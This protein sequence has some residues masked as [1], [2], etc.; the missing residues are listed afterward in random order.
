MWIR[1]YIY[2]VLI[3]PFHLLL[4]TVLVGSAMDLVMSNMIYGVVA[5]GFLIP[6]ERLL[7]KFFGFDN[8]GTLSAAGSFAG[9]ALFS[10][11]I[12]KINKSKSGGR[13]GSGGDDGGQDRT[14]TIRKG[15]V[16]GTNGMIDP[17]AVIAGTDGTGTSG[18]GTSG[19][20]TAKEESQVKDDSAEEEHEKKEIEK[21]R[22]AFREHAEKALTNEEIAKKQQK[23]L[24]EDTE[25]DEKESNSPKINT[26]DYMTAPALHRIGQGGLKERINLMKRDEEKG[27][28]GFGDR[29]LNA[30]GSAMYRAKLRTVKGVKRLPR[31]AGR[32]VRRTA[33]GTLGAIPL[34][35][36]GAAVGTA[37]GD[38][39]KAF[40]L[41]AAGGTAGYYGLNYYGDK[42][43]R[44][45]GNYA[46]DM[47]QGAQDAFWGTEK[48][49][50]EQA[51]FDKAFKANPDNIDALTKALGSREK[52]KDAMENGNVQAFL[53]NGITDPG[54]IGRAL[55]LMQ[56]LEEGKTLDNKGKRKKH[57]PLDR[58]AALKRAVAVAALNKSS[59]KAIYESN[60]YARR[61]FKENFTKQIV[62]Q[63][64][65][66]ISSTEARNRVEDVL[67][68][69][70]FID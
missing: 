65:G 40:Q 10:A 4:Y 37:S 21:Q 23:E 49:K 42:V 43:A 70:Q 53:N 51:R 62:E 66:T 13:G 1:E 60:S 47:K 50:L 61:A 27:T 29:L 56:R 5:I 32:F 67:A 9:G 44:T 68:E 63:S 14:P 58:E 36:M 38:V 11:M 19:T 48:K 3:Q 8:A 46:R 34:A 59:G 16:A 25:E 41:A 39:S 69:M 2:N 7:R 22:K 17:E 52:A 18:T 12:N 24:A 55:V 54:K 6:A 35:F 30:T 45:A 57:K 15:N 26:L 20:G 33:V 64:N 31:Q 28:P